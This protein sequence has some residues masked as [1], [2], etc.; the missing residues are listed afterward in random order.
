MLDRLTTWQTVRKFAEG[1]SERGVESER[2]SERSLS[3]PWQ[4]RRTNERTN[5]NGALSLRSAFGRSPPPLP[6]SFLFPYSRSE[7][8]P[9]AWY[10]YA[11]LVSWG[12]LAEDRDV[13]T[14][15]AKDGLWPAG[16]SSVRT[17][18]YPFLPSEYTQS[19]A[20]S[21][22]LEGG[23]WRLTEH[24]RKTG[25]LIDQCRMHASRKLG[26]REGLPAAHR[27]ANHRSNTIAL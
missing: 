15:L 2:A 10:I 6:S 7:D 5:V 26:A 3:S 4:G 24:V 21:T 25:S 13:R 22:C 12:K 8:S 27:T 19:G 1:A 9:Q 18:S 16:A 20:E 17:R 11:G 23:R 14:S